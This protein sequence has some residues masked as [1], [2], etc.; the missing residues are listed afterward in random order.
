M[1]TPHAGKIAYFIPTMNII[2]DPLCTK[3]AAKKYI[4]KRMLMTILTMK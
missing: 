3:M 1:E 4:R 2:L